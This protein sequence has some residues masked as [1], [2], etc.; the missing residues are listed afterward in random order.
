[1]LS[2]YWLEIN[3]IRFFLNKLKSVIAVTL[4]G[5]SF[6]SLALAAAKLTLSHCLANFNVII[7]RPSC[8]LVLYCDTAEK[9][10]VCRYCSQLFDLKMLN[11]ASTLRRKTNCSNGKIPVTLYV[12]LFSSV[13]TLR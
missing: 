7:L 5:S 6:Q 1:M 13:L 2:Y 3:E 10:L 12:S 4:D 9:Q 8:C 11:T